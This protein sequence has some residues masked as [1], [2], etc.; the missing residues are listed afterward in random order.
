MQSI[1]LFT[2]FTLRLHLH[3]LNQAF[4]GPKIQHFIISVL[5]ISSHPVFPPFCWQFRLPQST[6]SFLVLSISAIAHFLLLHHSLDTFFHT[7]SFP[8]FHCHCTVGWGNMKSTRRVLGHSLVRSLVCSHC[9]LICLLSI[10][11]F[12]CA[13]RCAHLLARSAALIHS[14]DPLHSFALSL[15]RSRA[16]GK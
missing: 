11:C 2:F 14:L 8:P 1:F 13:L 7:S 9:S 5:P 15:T 3:F 4:Y 10:A 12:T 6:C 16:H